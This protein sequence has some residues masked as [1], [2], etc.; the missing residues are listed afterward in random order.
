MLHI[1]QKWTKLGLLYAP[2]RQALL[3]LTHASVP[4]ARRLQGSLYRVYFSARDEASRSCLCWILVDIEKFSI[5]DGCSSP[6]FAP[7]TPGF[8]DEDGVMGCDLLDQGTALWLYYI[9]WN[10]AINVPFRNAIGLAAST[11]GGTTFHRMFEGPVVDRGIHDPCFVA[12]MCVI[13]DDQH[14]RMYYLSCVAWERSGKSLRHR[15]HIKQALS[16]DGLK[17]DRAGATAIDFAYPNEYAISVPRVLKTLK[18]YSMWYSYRGGPRGETYRIGYAESEN[19]TNWVRRDLDVELDIS[20]SGWDS[21]MI[22][23]P[24]VMRHAGDLF[25]FYN[26]NGYGRTG[27]GVARLDNKD[28]WGF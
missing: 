25:M 2:D 17:W 13:P 18:G 23:Y 11:D 19:G 1:A 15:Y 8:F 16:L 12:S 3:P 24:F 7:S 21:E 14:F 4:F 6:A 28:E 5:V 20:P 9:G 22:C 26:G 27:I 10:K